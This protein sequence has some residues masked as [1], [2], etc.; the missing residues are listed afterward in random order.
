MAEQNKTAQNYTLNLT[1]A[2]TCITHIRDDLRGEFNSTLYL[3][4]SIWINK[5]TAVFNWTENDLELKNLLVY[6][7][8]LPHVCVHPEALISRPQC[9]QQSVIT[10]SV[11]FIPH[12][13]P[14]RFITVMV[15]RQESV[16]QNVYK[17]NESQSFLHIPS[18][19]CW[20]QE[21]LRLGAEH[22]GMFG[23]WKRD[24]ICPTKSCGLTYSVK[25]SSRGTVVWTRD[26]LLC[27]VYVE[28]VSPFRHFSVTVISPR[29]KGKLFWLQIKGNLFISASWLVVNNS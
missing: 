22:R 26:Q 3:I 28:L 12:R 14:A 2:H 17:K 29:T 10:K 27:C 7:K 21:K 25:I 9:V 20:K 15:T 18:Q 4:V 19:A 8:K 24:F 13:P 16:P 11:S 1:Q 6:L 23:I 5:P